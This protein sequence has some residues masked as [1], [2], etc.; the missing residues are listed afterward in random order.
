MEELIKELKVVQSGGFCV[1]NSRVY[2]LTK[3]P[4]ALMLQLVDEMV[5][6][7]RLND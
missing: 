5:I 3:T 1:C 7:G 6:G 4:Y 2:V